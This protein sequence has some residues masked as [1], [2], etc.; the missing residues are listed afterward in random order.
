MET[1]NG[2]GRLVLVLVV[3]VLVSL[4]AACSAPETGDDQEAQATQYFLNPYKEECQVDRE[5]R[6]C[7]VAS[8][9]DTGDFSPYEGEI[10]N[11]AY[12]WGYGY[13][14]SG[15][16]DQNVFTVDEVLNKTAEEGGVQFSLVITG[17]GDRITQTGD[18]LY[19]I[20][21]E[22]SFTC[23]PSADCATLD[24]VI[25]RKV[26]ITFEFRTPAD[27]ADPYTLLDWSSE[28]AAAQAGEEPA[29]VA[30]HWVLESFTVDDNVDEAVLPGSMPTAD[31]T[32]GDSFATGTVSGSGGCNDYT[33]AVT[34]A[35]NSISIS[36]IERTEAQ[37]IDPP[38]IMEQE[39]NF[40]SGLTAAE[41]F[42]VADGRLE[43]VYDDGSSILHFAAA[44]E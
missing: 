35:G 6:L 36:D 11:F 7:Y 10:E 42:S 37:C 43:I 1:I 22:K 5:L 33:G 34:I 28:S 23:D 9:G 16:G 39:T 20:Y 27:P 3:L 8:V 19:E 15:S 18:G 17:G 2:R 32:L 13:A 40:L 14:L 21:G 12:E 41:S 38:G 44:E 29:L 30:N 26:P 4:L 24:S 25:T 31:F